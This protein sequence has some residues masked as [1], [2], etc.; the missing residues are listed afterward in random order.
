MT[1]QVVS[2]AVKMPMTNLVSLLSFWVK[3]IH[4]PSAAAAVVVVNLSSTAAARYSLV[5]NVDGTNDP[6]VN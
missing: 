6:L 4:F 2:A 5:G 3:F 1:I